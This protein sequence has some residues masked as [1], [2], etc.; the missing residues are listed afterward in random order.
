MRAATALATKVSEAEAYGFPFTAKR[1]SS[2][3]FPEFANVAHSFHGVGK[4]HVPGGRSHADDRNRSPGVEVFHDLI[5][6]D[7]VSGKASGDFSC[8]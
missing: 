5:S 7:A 3:P 4:Q 6:W 2:A 8:W 1:A